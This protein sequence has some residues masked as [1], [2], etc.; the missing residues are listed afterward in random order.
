MR[1]ASSKD[2]ESGARVLQVGP[3]FVNHVRRWAEHA[4]ELGCTVFAAGHVHPER[5]LVELSDIVEGVEVAPTEL[6]QLGAAP[7]VGWLRDVIRRLEPD[8]IH[9]HFLPSWGYR[10][11]LSGHRP[12]IVTPW[13]SDI[14]LA[15]G[16]RREHAD[17]AL[18]SAD[19]VLARSPHMLREILARGVPAE[20]VHQVD[21]GVDLGRFRPASPQEQRRVRH[22]LDI[23]PGPVILS[24]RAGTELYNLDIVL[25]AF[26]RLRRRLPDA[27]LLMVHNGAPFSRP[28]RASLHGIAAD[29]GVRVVGNVPH[30]DIH[31]YLTV[32]TA[33]I[34]IPR[35]DGSPSSVWETLACGVPMVLSD[36]PQI[37]ERVGASGAVRLVEPRPDAVASALYEIVADP[38]LRDRM[39][40]AGRAWAEANADQREQVERLGKV[41]AAM[42]EGSPS[43]AR[44]AGPPEAGPHRSA[45]HG[46]AKAAS[47]PPVPS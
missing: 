18:R 43:Q 9:A 13:G 41:Y 7:H 25:E 19:A 12:L 14:Y 39:S 24:A 44:L 30:A 31:K 37:D 8:L 21:L 17:R 20:R 23:P 15:S 2:T 45:A 22:E 5:H 46:K 33:G 34:S 28:L 11:A 35:S 27:T 10:A 38:P 26:H 6:R 16:T 47:A 29:R 1:A 36:L 42:T 4:A 40:Q 32:A 3:L